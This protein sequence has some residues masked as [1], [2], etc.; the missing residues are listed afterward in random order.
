MDAKL[1]N[2]FINAT[3]NVLGTMANVKAKPGK[4]YLKKDNVAQGD[5]T[6]IIGITG[7]ANGT[8]S[9]TFDEGSILNIVSKM[10]GEEM[11]QID[12]SIVDAVGELTNMIS[13]QA[14]RELEQ[15]GRIF[16]AAIPSVIT[17]KKHS[18]SHITSGPKIAIPFSTDA[19]NFTIEVCLDK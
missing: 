10:F 14:R 4:P 1:I 3:L 8:I 5:V 16:E 15:A 19:G 17:G 13:G 2:P 6:G 12:D 7:E 9:V 18:I 11:T